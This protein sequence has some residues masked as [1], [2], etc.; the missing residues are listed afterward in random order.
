M[1]SISQTWGTTPQERQQ[2]YPCDA[3]ISTPDATLYRGV[4]IYAPAATI[5]RWLCQLR[6]AP[7]SYDWIDNGGKQS[8]RALI[9]GLDQLV[10]GQEVMTIFELVA[11]ERNRHLT[12]RIKQGSASSR[13]FGDLAVSYL[14]E[15]G[16]SGPCR[17][18]VKLVVNYSNS[19]RGRFMRHFLPWGDLF[20][21]R[22]QLLNLKQLAEQSHS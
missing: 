5:F 14:L 17:L 2:R 21:M 13:T 19:L 15:S 8:P 3:V 4:T 10:V 16:E 22:R 20:M 7:Y 11:F 6:V 1:S 12:L 18:L 9:E